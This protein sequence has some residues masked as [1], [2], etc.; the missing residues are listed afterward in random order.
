MKLLDG[1]KNKSPM[2]PSK[3][4]TGKSV[5]ADTTRSAAAPTPSTLGPRCA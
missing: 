4:P 2:A 1:L 3:T 5:N